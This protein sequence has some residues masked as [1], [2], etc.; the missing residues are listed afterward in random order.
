MQCL[1]DRQ[2]N[3]QLMQE[4]LAK[5]I[6]TGMNQAAMMLWSRRH[7]QPSAVLPRNGVS[8]QLVTL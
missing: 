4:V 8:Q 3:D 5:S 1:R 6:S 2:H 7:W